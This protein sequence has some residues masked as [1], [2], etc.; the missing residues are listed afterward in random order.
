MAAE[1]DKVIHQIHGELIEFRSEMKTRAGQFEVILKD[2]DFAINGDGNGVPGMRVRMDRLEQS[3][4]TRERHIFAIWTAVL[5]S[6]L[7]WIS[8]LFHKP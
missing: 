6:T 1:T 4:K 3:T 5:A 7:A 8:G 2:H